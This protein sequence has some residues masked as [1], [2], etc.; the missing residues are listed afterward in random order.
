MPRVQKLAN[1]V[2]VVCDA[3]A[4]FETL[5]LSVVAGRGARWEDGPR[6][7]WSHLLEHMVFK[8]A[9]GRSARDIVEV[10]EAA[11]G[12]INAATG[13]ERTSFQIRALAG[14]LPLAMAVTADLIQRPTLDADDLA[15]EVGVVAQEIAEAADTPDDQV[16]ELAQS[17]AFA[18][19][20][21]GRPILGTR[22]SIET[23]TPE[24]LERWR[25]QLYAPDRLVVSASGAVDETELLA[26]A[27][28]LFGKTTTPAAAPAEPAAFTGGQALERRRLEQAHLVFLLPT[29]GIAD[30]DHW[31]V[32]LFAEML[33]G[34]MSSRLFQEARERLGLAYAIDSWSDAYADA[35][36]LGVYAGCAAADAGRLAE[37]A[38]TQ[39]RL[40]AMGPEPAE[41]ARAKT[42]IKASL[43]M[44]R[45]SLA[46]RAEQAAAQIL[47]FDRLLPPGE[48][49]DAIDAVG[50]D[51]IVRV[52]ER[53]L[54]ERR[55][56]ISVLG[57]K[58]A[59]DAAGRFEATLFA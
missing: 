39:I 43:F 3:V 10:I 29:S 2:T 52:A 30:P 48:L 42:Q 54:T 8:G 16:F 34:G 33:G 25:A 32:R 12:H 15:K 59:M 5:A 55:A 1:G 7:G 23:S 46:A 38:A 40:L 18:G 56:A 6:N 31:V 44:G 13:Q 19:Q 26:Q 17:A 53:V 22:A 11:G 14:G 58:P 57:P 51:D 27:E 37:V 35:G 41:L 20:P 4:G 49:A 47:A 9:G 24:A 45:E 21:L 28:A 36:V 50:L